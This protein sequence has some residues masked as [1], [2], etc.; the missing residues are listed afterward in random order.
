MYQNNGKREI[1]WDR[2]QAPH[3]PAG[4]HNLLVSTGIKCGNSISCKWW[5]WGL[6][7]MTRVNHLESACQLEI[8]QWTFSIHVH[9]FGVY[10]INQ[11]STEMAIRIP[12]SLKVSAYRVDSVISKQRECFHLYSFIYFLKILSS[13]SSQTVSSQDP[14]TLENFWVSQR[15]YGYVG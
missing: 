2:V 6:N 5:L 1:V 15:V 14:L 10:L 9:F 3:L 8:T 7:G 4:P 12:V 13:S 11:V